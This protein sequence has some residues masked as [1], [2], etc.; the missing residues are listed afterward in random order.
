[1]NLGIKDITNL[2]KE[3]W[4]F[5]G[6]GRFQLLPFEETGLKFILFPEF[7]KKKLQYREVDLLI[8]RLF[9][10]VEFPSAC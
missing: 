6:Y 10:R 5:F 2:R 9:K 8:K 3:E 7:E 4:S 1:M